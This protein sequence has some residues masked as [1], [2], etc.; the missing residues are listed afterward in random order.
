M[1]HINRNASDQTKSKLLTVLKLTAPVAMAYIPLG[2]AFGIFLVAS[3]INWYWAPL[4]ALIIFAGSIEFLAVS[5]IVSGLPLGIV[6]WTTLIVNFRHIFYG[7]SFPIAQMTS[8]I[9]KI[10]GVYALTDET[11]AITSAGEGSQL[12]GQSIT[13]LQIISHGW[14]ISGALIGACI[15]TIIPPEIKGF[16]FALT[17]M[18]LILAVDAIRHSQDLGL[19]F[20][21]V[22]SCIVGF[23]FE[24]YVIENSFLVS[25]LITYLL[26]ISKDYKTREQSIQS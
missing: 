4:S 26:L 19:V 6:A 24:V 1:K 9:Q 22:T 12:D 15:G 7:L 17:S 10:Y 11:Y 18:F 23:V 5:F 3:G 20:Y 13:L 14:W 8:P 16:E 2:I 25:G 21:A